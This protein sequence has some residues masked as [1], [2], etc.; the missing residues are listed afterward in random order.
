MPK[1]NF[2]MSI[3]YMLG[4]INTT[5]NMR[6]YEQLKHDNTIK[7]MT[8]CKILGFQDKFHLNNLHK[9]KEK[10]SWSKSHQPKILF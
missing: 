6:T 2:P 7:L 5:K 8:P 3:T 9:K 1:Y 10:A 4:T